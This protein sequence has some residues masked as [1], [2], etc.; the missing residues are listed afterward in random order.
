MCREGRIRLRIVDNLEYW[1]QSRTHPP[2]LTESCSV[3]REMPR[4]S[5]VWRERGLELKRWVEH[6]AQDD[7][8][9]QRNPFTPWLPGAGDRAKAREAETRPRPAGRERQCSVAGAKTGMLKEPW[10]QESLHG[11]G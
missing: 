6:T 2:V 8:C 7:R 5:C 9:Q 11:T 10:S 3:F 1:N 4:E